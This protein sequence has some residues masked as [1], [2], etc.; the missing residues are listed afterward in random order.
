MAIVKLTHIVRPLVKAIELSA[1]STQNHYGEYMG[2]LEKV[3]A[4]VD[5][6]NP[7]VYLAVGIA[8]VQAG[9][10]KAGVLSALRAMGHLS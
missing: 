4:M 9:A 7:N 5:T 2:A 3:A 10:S 1:P 8:F 6:K